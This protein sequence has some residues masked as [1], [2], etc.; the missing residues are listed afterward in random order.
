MKAAEQKS[1]KITERHSQ[2]IENIERNDDV[3]SCKVFSTVQWPSMQAIWHRGTANAR[4]SLRTNHEN[5]E[6]IQNS[7]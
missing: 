7:Q 6:I 1:I 4:V 3:L 2:N 5:S